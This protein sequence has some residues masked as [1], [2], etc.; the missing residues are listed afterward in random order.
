MTSVGRPTKLTD[1]TLERLRYAR[2]KGL[3]KKD[4]AIAAGI[5]ESTYQ[6]WQKKAKEE[7]AAPEYVE[8]LELMDAAEV[9]C[10]L[11]ALEAVDKA[12]DKDWRAAAWL[13]GHIR[14]D[15]FSDKPSQ[16]TE[17]SG[18]IKITFNAEHK[19]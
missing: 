9:D 3:D 10:V 17:H 18:E 19:P 15:R 5:G 13:A 6:L 7:D 1:E 4:A 16:K 14:P 12:K 8:F 11:E 2:R